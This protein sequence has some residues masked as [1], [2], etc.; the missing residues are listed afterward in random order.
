METIQIDVKRNNFWLTIAVISLILAY[1]N[2][3]FWALFAISL[4]L[5]IKSLNN[6]CQ[7]RLT[8]FP[9]ILKYE[10]LTIFSTKFVMFSHEDID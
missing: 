2:Q 9:A 8:L 4:L 7:Y 10:I 6:V 5:T 1:V 3:Y